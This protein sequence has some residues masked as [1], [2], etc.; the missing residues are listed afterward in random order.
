M[1]VDGTEVLEARWLPVASPRCATTI[2]R[3]ALT[4]LASR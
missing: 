2:A 3:D 1:H 4:R